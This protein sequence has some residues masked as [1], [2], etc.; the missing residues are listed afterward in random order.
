[1]T[2]NNLQINQISNRQYILSPAVQSGNDKESSNKDFYQEGAE[3]PNLGRLGLGMK[4][5]HRKTNGI[6]IKQNNMIKKIG[7]KF[8]HLKFN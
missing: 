1:M 7:N 8:M 5:F 4:V 6:F 2:D 3:L